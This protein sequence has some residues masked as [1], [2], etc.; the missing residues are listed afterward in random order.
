[1]IVPQRKDI[2]TLPVLT[3]L[4]TL[5]WIGLL[6]F[7]LL[8]L[9]S[10]WWTHT[11]YSVCERQREYAH[12]VYVRNGEYIYRLSA[13]LELVL[14]LHNIPFKCCHVFSWEFNDMIIR[15][16]QKKSGENMSVCHNESW[17]QL[18]S[19]AASHPT[20]NKSNNDRRDDV[21]LYGFAF[22]KL[23]LNRT[24]W[25]LSILFRYHSCLILVLLIR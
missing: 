1:M 5:P 18:L 12:P 8:Q 15:W 25:S 11:E 16:L 17:Q 10:V 19:S 14:Q 9:C 7:T 4:K 24:F 3:L 2:N 23:E 6:C 21:T 22:P 20:L 13:V